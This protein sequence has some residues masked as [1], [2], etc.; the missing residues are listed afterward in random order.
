ML[1]RSVRWK[2]TAGAAVYNV[3]RRDDVAPDWALVRTTADKKFND[4]DVD[5]ELVYDYHVVAENDAG[6]SPGSN[7]DSGWALGE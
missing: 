4:H 5:P 6:S 2:R 3:Y 7:V 1:Q